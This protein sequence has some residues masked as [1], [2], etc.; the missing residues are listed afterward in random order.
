M[1]KVLNQDTLQKA[2]DHEMLM[3][4]LLFDE[5]PETCSPEALKAALEENVGA[6]ENISDKP[7]MPMF[8]VKNFVA[9]FNDGKKVPVLANFLAPLEF[10]TEIDELKRSQF[11]D[12][13]DGNAI[14]DNAKYCVNVFGMM[15]DCLEYKQQAELLLA[16]IDAALKC[17]PT[18]KAIY[19]ISSG[20]LT[21]PQ[22]FEECKRYDLSGRFIRLAVNARF[23]TI[24][25]SDDMIVDT[26]GFYTFGAADVQVHFHGLDP[27]AVVNYVYNIASYQFDNDF[28]IK[29]GETVDGLD[30]NGKTSWDIQWKTQY[31]DSL[32]QP[33]RT[34]LDVN[35][36]Q[37]AA[38]N[39]G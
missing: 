30:E 16:E 39:R 6:V 32:I 13:E 29:S 17:Y 33:V 4:Q 8:S 36:G 34:V 15:A 28:P 21:T 24:S 22:Q 23:F 20:K 38:G 19:M 12:V 27:N 10:K 26:L 31:E 14:I 3:A 9:E 2:P 5:Q 25:G 11:W 1:N 18:C 7:D 37:Y 35:C